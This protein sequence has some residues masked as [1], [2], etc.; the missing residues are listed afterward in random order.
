[1]NQV[2]QNEKELLLD[3]REVAEMIGKNHAH[4]TRDITSY[5]GYIS[6]NPKLVSDDYFIESSYA[7]GTGKAYKCFKLTKMGCEMV[8]N[9]L[10]GAKGVQFTATYVKRF[11]ELEKKVLTFY[12]PSTYSEALSLAAEQARENEQLKLEVAENQPKV[13]YCDQILKSSTLTNTT[14]IAKDYGMS[15]R[16]FNKL[17]HDIGVQFE[18]GGIWILYQTFADKGYTQSRTK[19]I[20]KDF[21]KVYTC[22]T[23]EGRLFLYRKL[24][25]HNILPLI[26]K[27]EVRANEN[28]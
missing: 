22:W 18:Q 14:V 7:A 16:K 12:I 10:T 21:A 8:A 2:T 27:S 3:S 25:A 23:Q 19:S 6:Q 4:L 28:I 1:M 26:E 20:N 13:D 15:A 5:I 11:N 24:K 17:L 9:K